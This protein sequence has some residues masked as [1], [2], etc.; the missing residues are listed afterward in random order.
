MA[1]EYRELWAERCRY[2]TQVMHSS[3]TPAPTITMHAAAHWRRAW[4]FAVL[5]RILG[6]ERR[7]VL[8]LPSATQFQACR[9]T[10][11]V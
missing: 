3:G 5:Q 11:Q 2:F 6:S 9:S 4:C 7:T 1:T 10:P 8:P